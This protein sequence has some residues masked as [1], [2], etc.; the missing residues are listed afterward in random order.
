M[1]SHYFE[2]AELALV[3]H[4][5]EGEARWKTEFLRPY[6]PF[7]KAECPEMAALEAFFREG[8]LDT[9]PE[10]EDLGEIENGDRWFHVYK[11]GEHSYKALLSYTKGQ[12]VASM[13][14]DIF[15]GKC[16][17]ALAGGGAEK[18][19]SGGTMMMIAFSIFAALRRTLLMHASVTVNGGKAYLFLGRSGTGK[20]THSDLWVEHIPG[21]R[22]LNDDNPAVRVKDGQVEVFGTP[23]SGKRNYYFNRHFEVGAFVQLEQHGENLIE[24]LKPIK[25]FSYVLPSSSTMMW[26]KQNFDGVVKTAEAVVKAIPVYYLKC[27]A[28]REAAILC[29]ETI[30]R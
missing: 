6:E 12:V 10:G 2:V 25:G 29:H 27:R 18:Y 24:K 21:S 17:I 26:D 13:K 15:S 8:G 23:W 28:D 11:T 5:E 4:F 22:I 9:E 30:A 3:L 19:Q 1:E 16:T 20:S 7:R 14:I